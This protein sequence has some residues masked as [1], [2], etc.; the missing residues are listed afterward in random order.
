M[1]LPLC[2]PGMPR[3]YQDRVDYRYTLNVEVAFLPAQAP[4]AKSNGPAKAEKPVAAPGVGTPSQLEPV[5]RNS[6]SAE[7][8]AQREPEHSAAPLPLD[9]VRR[10]GHL[11]TGSFSSAQ[12]CLRRLPPI[13]F[14]SSGEPHE[15]PLRPQHPGHGMASLLLRRLGHVDVG[16][17]G[18]QG[19]IRMCSSPDRFAW[20]LRIL[21]RRLVP[22]GAA[23]RY[24]RVPFRFLGLQEPEKRFDD[25]TRL[26]CMI[27]KVQCCSSM[28]PVRM[29]FPDISHSTLT[30]ALRYTPDYT[31]AAGH[32][33]STHP[34]H[35]PPVFT[36]WTPHTPSFSSQPALLASSCSPR[37][38]T[39]TFRTPAITPQNPN[40][41]GPA[42]G[43]P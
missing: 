6:L 30:A 35:A 32:S 22:N 23:E 27:F 43:A 28:R 8:N 10:S 12:L 7:S 42:L 21:L 31:H 36:P 41:S 33:I 34:A 17:V 5:T 14:V 3:T 18:T 11:A 38:L 40:H 26:C 9:E 2:K 29:L 37:H 16:S 1:L 13:S 25:I 39:H 20:C 24:R 4:S 19:R 15:L